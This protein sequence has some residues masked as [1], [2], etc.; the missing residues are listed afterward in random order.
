MNIVLL[1]QAIALLC[2]FAVA[3]ST[4]TAQHT[5]PT[6]SGATSLYIE[7]KGQIGDQHGKPNHDVRFVI[8]RSGLNIQLRQ[9]GFSYDSYT[10]DRCELPEDT[11]QRH[12]PTKFRDHP[13]EEITYYFHRV[14]VD[15]VGAN[16]KP[17]ITATG[18]SQD[19]LNYYTHITQQVHGDKGATDVR[20]YARVTYHDVWPGIDMEWFIDDQQRPEYQFVIRPGG[21]VAA[22]QL[23]YRGAHGTRLDEE[24]LVLDVQHGPIRESLPRSYVQ[25]TGSTADVRYRALGNDVYG[26]TVP[27]IDVAMGET[28]VIDPMPELLWA[29]YYGGEGLDQCRSVELTASDEIALAGDTQSMSAIASAGAHQEMFLGQRDAFVA[30]ITS[31]GTRKWGTYYGGSGIEYGRDVAV[32][33]EGNIVLVGYTNSTSAIASADAYQVSHG[34]GIDDAFLVV[35]TNTGVRLWGTYFGGIGNDFGNAVAVTRS[36]DLVLGGTTTS[37]TTIATEDVHQVVFGGIRDAFVT[38]F[39]ITG[40]RLWGTYYGGSG[41]DFGYA[42]AITSDGNIVLAGETGSSTGIATLGTHQLTHGLGGLNAFVATLT[43][44]GARRWGTYHGRRGAYACSGLAVTPDDDIVLA[45]Y[46]DSRTGIRT[47]GTHQ[48]TNAGGYDAFLTVLTGVGTLRW[49]T[50]YGG[51]GTDYGNDVDVTVT[52]DILLVGQTSSETAIATRGSYRDKRGTGIK[53]FLVA[54]ANNGDRRWGTYFGGSLNDGGRALA[55][56]RGGGIV[57]AGQTISNTGIATEGTHQQMLIGDKDDAFVAMFRQDTATSIATDEPVPHTHTI[58]AIS[59]NPSS[60]HTVITTSATTDAVLS[61]ADVLGRVH[62]RQTIAAGSTATTISTH[63]L[64]SGSYYLRLEPVAGTGSVQAH[65]Q[66]LIVVP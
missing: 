35:F 37:A 61:V 66:A 34:G 16:P 4:S 24:H 33:Q 46:T 11:T 15:L 14:D 47:S 3:N 5:L 20:G 1:S 13:N 50:F 62:V 19:Y 9:N 58:A 31:R 8:L 44:A 38:V 6:A 51:T 43:S 56:T 63:G 42:L 21:N 54:F 65:T 22:I 25:S 55:V 36:G 59:P 32:T 28:L 41:E 10:V 26:F 29:S 40:T 49:E 64:P 48:D 30:L 45:G 39:T 12:L 17:L 52:G 23:R 53:A 7:N 60:G 18:V 2:L 27:P 57:L